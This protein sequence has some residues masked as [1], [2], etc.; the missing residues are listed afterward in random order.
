ML[1][2]YRRVVREH[3]FNKCWDL[4]ITWAE[5]ENL[6][7]DAEV[8][9]EH[10]FDDLRIKQICLLLGWIEQLHVVYVVDHE[11]RLRSSARCTSRIWNTGIPATGKGG[12]VPMKCVMCE[13]MTVVALRPKAMERDGRLAVIRDVPVEV[14]DCCG[15]VYLDTEV[16]KQLDLLF[17]Q[18]LESPV[19]EAVGH[20][21]PAA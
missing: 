14:C 20:Y 10:L 16:V 19:D 6:L 11:R 15:E 18:M 12:C 4:D 3:V 7:V 13:G 5:V 2:D 1:D 8:V 21:S 9:E 17:R